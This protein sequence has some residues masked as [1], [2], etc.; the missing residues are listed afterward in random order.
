MRRRLPEEV[1]W[2][3]SFWILIYRDMRK[4]RV[5]VYFQAPERTNDTLLE[6]MV[7]PINV[8]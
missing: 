3:E 5:R 4:R 2:W 1:V 6:D 7:N 8:A